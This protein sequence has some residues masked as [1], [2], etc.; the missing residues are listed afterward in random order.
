MK[1]KFWGELGLFCRP[2]YKAEPH[3]YPVL[4][5]TAAK[6]LIEAIFWKPEINYSIISITV[7]NPIRYLNMTRNMG[8]KRQNPK[9]VKKWMKNEGVGNYRIDRDRA[10]R[11][12]TL[13]S[14]PAYIVEFDILVKKYANE[15]KEK[16]L[17]Q[18]K[19]RID[20]GQC[21]KQPYFGCREYAAYFSWP[22]ESDRSDPSLIGNQDLG[23]MPK[24]L[25]FI[26]SND[27]PVSCR[28]RSPEQYIKGRFVTEYFHA[29]MKDGKIQVN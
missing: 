24:H 10:Q 9:V 21:F 1:V 25:H 12:H 15:P 19:R 4:T 6:G 8:Q 18:L 23:M 13:L 16:Y 27:G 29:L 5:P 26:E 17:S 28:G 14:R 11:H 20:R 22:D 7:L 2:E 3:S